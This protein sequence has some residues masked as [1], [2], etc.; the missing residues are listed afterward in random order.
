M[1]FAERF[2]VA[3]RKGRCKDEKTEAETEE[4]SGTGAGGHDGAV[5]AGYVFCG[6][7]GES[8]FGPDGSFL[9]KGRRLRGGKP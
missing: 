4:S 2:S 6:G 9:H 5:I 8:R 3:K 7:R 1:R